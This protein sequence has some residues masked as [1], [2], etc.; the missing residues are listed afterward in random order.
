[1]PDVEFGHR[2]I[3]GAGDAGDRAKRASSSLALE[4]SGSPVVAGGSLR[5]QAQ[6]AGQ[7]RDSGQAQQ[8]ARSSCLVFWTLGV[9]RLDAPASNGIA[10]Q[11]RR[12]KLAE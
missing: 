4:A 5:H 10:G 11:R 6:P 1:M 8:R 12:I 9:G 2:E 3:A 7:H